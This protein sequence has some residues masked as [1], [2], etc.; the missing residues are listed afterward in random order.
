MCLNVLIY[1]NNYIVQY[2]NGIGITFHLVW[3]Y[4]VLLWWELT[5]EVMS[6][7]I[8][9]QCGIVFSA[10]LAAEAGFHFS[11]IGY[12]NFWWTKYSLHI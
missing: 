6:P 1:L 9:P 12:L 2:L 8:I 4:C 7:I 11:N 3:F 5:A 10:F